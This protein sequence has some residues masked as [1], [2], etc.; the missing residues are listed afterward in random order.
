MAEKALD[1]AQAQGAGTLED[2]L[3]QSLKVLAK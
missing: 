3:R 2:L 1:A